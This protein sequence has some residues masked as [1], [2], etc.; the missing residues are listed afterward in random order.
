MNAGH[1]QRLI[2]SITWVLADNGITGKP[3]EEIV[4]ETAAGV[5][6][7]IWDNNSEVRAK[8]RNKKEFIRNLTHELRQRGLIKSRYE[9]EPVI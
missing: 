6:G 8:F 3:A 2:E 7:A 5:V 1:Y 4:I 9:R